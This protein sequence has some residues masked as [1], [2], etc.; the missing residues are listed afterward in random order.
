MRRAI[1]QQL[2]IPMVEGH[3]EAFLERAKR[4]IVDLTSGLGTLDD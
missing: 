1:G 2:A 4:M 3:V